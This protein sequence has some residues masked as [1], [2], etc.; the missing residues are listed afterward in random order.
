MRDEDNDNSSER[1][2]AAFHRS[3]GWLVLD[4]WAGPGNF[5]MGFESETEAAAEARRRNGPPLTVVDENFVVW[6]DD[7]D[8]P[9]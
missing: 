2:K 7:D 4:L 9:F 6:D 3:V 8:V 1:Y 5:E